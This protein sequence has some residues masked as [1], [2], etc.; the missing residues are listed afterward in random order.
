M[1]PQRY[2]NLQDQASALP[3]VVPRGDASEDAHR[4]GERAVRE[5]RE[6]DESERFIDAGF[7]RF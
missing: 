6:I 5:E 7:L 4:S 2:A 1:F 3:A